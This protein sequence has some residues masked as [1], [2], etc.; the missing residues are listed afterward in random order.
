MRSLNKSDRSKFDSEY[1]MSPADRIPAVRTLS[2]NDLIAALR[3]GLAD[4]N[5]APTHAIFLSLIYPVVG[6][7]LAHAT[8]SMNLLPLLFPAVAGFAILGP[9]AAVGLC[10]ISRLRETGVAVT[11][12]NALGVIHAKSIL[13]ILILGAV[14]AALF[15]VWLYAANELYA[16]FFGDEVPASAAALAHQIFGTAAGWKMMLVGDLI[17]A[18]FAV[19]GFAISVIAFPMLIDRDTDAG[20]AALTSIRAVVANPVVMAEWGLIVAAALVLGSIPLLIGLAVV[21]PVLGHATW[22]LY[23]RVVAE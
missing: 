6:L 2:Q 18:V 20:T 1:A 5:A 23:R 8:F 14:L 21:M 19:A 17:G 12:R 4:F 10:E 13:G 22:H 11:W 16:A 3:E 7:L 9:F 15:G